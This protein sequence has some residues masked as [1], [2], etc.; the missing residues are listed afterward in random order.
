M[1]EYRETIYSKCR[2]C[3]DEGEHKVYHAKEMFFGTGQE[4]TYFKCDQ[5]QCIQI[6]GIPENLGEFYGEGYYSFK[7]PDIY[8]P[9]SGERI[10][11]KILDVGCGAGKWLAEKYEQGHIHLLGCD[12]FIEKDLFYE[13]CIEIKKCTIHEIE[14]V[15]DLIRLSDS[16]EHMADPLEVLQSV[17]RL[18]HENGMCLLSIPVIPNAT[19][20]IFHEYWYEWDAPRH[21]FLHSVKSMEY[22]CRRAGLRIKDIN[23]N[24]Q[25]SQ[26]ISSLLY[27]RGIPYLEQSREVIRRAFT[28]KE[29]DGFLEL[30]AELNQKGYGDHAV[31]VIEKEN[32]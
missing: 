18:L 11:T 16:F 25:I 1:P 28:Q 14:G 22:L 24:S 3:G 19:Y 15:F 10:E 9:L 5:C 23:Y 12:P 4:F 21:L 17:S 27:Q 2:L 8:K 13:P 20:D 26:F 29:I 32:K 6:V 7:R 30:T 31:F